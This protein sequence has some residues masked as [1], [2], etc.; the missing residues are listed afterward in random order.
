MS[1]CRRLEDLHLHGTSVAS[2]GVTWTI[3]LDSAQLVLL[4]V[5]RTR[6]A[7]GTN[8]L[9]AHNRPTCLRKRGFKPRWTKW[10]NKPRL[11]RDSNLEGR[12]K[13]ERSAMS[14]FQNKGVV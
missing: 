5:D 4:T 3:T 7:P 14:M 12:A 10:P 11:S 1:F 6:Q 13:S 8:L 2:R 9:V